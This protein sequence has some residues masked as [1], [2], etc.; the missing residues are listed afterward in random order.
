M[1][2]IQL[3]QQGGSQTAARGNRRATIRYRCAPAT[4][5]KVFSA[6][7][8]EFQRAWILELSVQGIG[9]QLS[10]AV[11]AGRALLVAVKSNDGARTFELS[12][13]VMR[14]HPLPQGEWYLGCELTAI[15]SADDLEQLL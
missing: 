5:G 2:Q 7:D 4:I 12:A 10:R 8:H 3:L 13:K 11:D 6:D 9:L 1:S 15:L 14:C